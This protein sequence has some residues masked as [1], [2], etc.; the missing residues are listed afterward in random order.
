MNFKKLTTFGA[1]ALIGGTIAKAWRVRKDAAAHAE[2][3]YRHLASSSGPHTTF[4]LEQVAHLPEIA[5]RYFRH[6]IAPGTPLY[7]AVELEMEGTFLLDEKRGQRS[8]Q[9]LARQVLRTPDQFVWLPEMRSGLI[10]ISGSDGLYEG[11]AW[12]RFWLLGLVP[13][14]QAKTSRDLVRSAQFRAAI[15]SAMWLPSSLLAKN[16]AEWEQIEEH[17]ARITLR[18]FEPA[19]VLNVNVDSHGAIRTIMGNRWSS[20]NPEKVFRLQPFGGTALAEGSFQGFTI[21]THIEAGNHFGEDNYVPFFQARIVR[22]S[23]R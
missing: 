19:I 10:T 11:Q 13:V 7:S 23:F 21:A 16:G 12:T 1:V 20:A 14:A 6:S 9:M 2:C 15:E 18:R 4:S 17:L 5:Q 3:A 8:L 22:A